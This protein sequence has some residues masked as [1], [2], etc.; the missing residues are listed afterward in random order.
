MPK[1][2]KGY[3][4]EPSIHGNSIVFVSDDDLWLANIGEA[5]NAAR[6]TSSVGRV[7]SPR[8]SPDGKYIAYAGTEEGN[9]EVYIIA[10]DGGVPKRVTYRGSTALRVVCWNKN[11]IIFAEAKINSLRDITRPF[12]MPLLLFNIFSF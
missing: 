5:S 12:S 8:F 6:L 4:R 3:Y 7:S 2:D 1:G 10:S 11:K 9:M